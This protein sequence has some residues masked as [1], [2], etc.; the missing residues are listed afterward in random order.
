MQV[1]YWDPTSPR[2]RSRWLRR[3][4]AMAFWSSLF[5]TML[6]PGSLKRNREVGGSSD[7]NVQEVHA[8]ESRHD[9]R[10]EPPH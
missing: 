6:D 5:L 1:L 8:E 7:F 4:F 9:A 10:V 3:A 2:S